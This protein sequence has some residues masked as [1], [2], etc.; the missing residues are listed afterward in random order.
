[1]TMVTPM[2]VVIATAILTA[3]I[4]KLELMAMSTINTPTVYPVTSTTPPKMIVATSKKF[5]PPML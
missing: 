5:S 4:L 1:M 3:M 2:E